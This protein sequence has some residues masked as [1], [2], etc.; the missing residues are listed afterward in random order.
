V[1]KSGGFGHLQKGHGVAFADLDN[2]GDQDVFHQIGGFFPTDAF[3]NALYEN[4]GHG[5]HFL[6]VQVQGEKTNRNGVGARIK[7]IVRTPQG[8]REIHRAV[9]SVSSFG[10][11][12]VSRQQIGLGDAT[13]ITKMEITWPMSGTNQVFENVPMDGFIRVIEGQDE[14]EKMDLP[15]IKF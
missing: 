12:P 4:P 7:L 9:G 11:S 2:D 1:T 6:T 5:N 8:E 14:F 10:G 13:A 3:R 15:A